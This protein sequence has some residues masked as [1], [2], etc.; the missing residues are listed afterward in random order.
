MDEA[1]IWAQ[2]LYPNVGGFGS[3]NF[4]RIEDEQLGPLHGLPLSIKDL[5]VTFDSSPAVLVWQSLN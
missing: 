2:V 3:E 5:V 4:L 1:S